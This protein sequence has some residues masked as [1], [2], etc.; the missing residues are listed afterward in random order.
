MR[1]IV[2]KLG[3]IFYVVG[4]MYAQQEPQYTQYIYATQLINP[5]YISTKEHISANLIY[6][7]QWLGF[8]GAP[9]TASFTMDTPMDKNKRIALGLSV[10]HDE[11]G[12][13]Q[14]TTMTI[15]YGYTIQ[16]QFDR[17]LSFGLK[18]GASVLDIDFQK[19]NAYSSTDP[20]FQ[21]NIDD[22]WQPHI[23]AGVFYYTPKFFLGIST[24]NF[25][26]TKYFAQN[27]N[28]QTIA[29]HRMHT[30]WLG[31][32]VIDWTSD[33][34]F[35][36][37]LLLKATMGAPLEWDVS[38]NFMFYE[39][40]QFGVVYRSSASIAAVAGFQIV[41]SWFVG[42]GYDRHL[43]GLDYYNDGTYELIMQFRLFDQKNC[44]PKNRF[45]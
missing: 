29:A 4:T 35:K 17:R 39:K 32:Y 21:N 3:W 43:G 12:P 22:R 16:L 9:K 37:T 7:T 26:E 42:F 31:G 41:K 25:L 1:G 5:A 36:P 33:I 24:P 45:Y 27:N 23:G 38:A 34:K 30:Y 44:C 14:Q 19:L 20:T 18:F 11:I 28:K 40:I 6:R 8:S 2:Y 10:L 13:A 15:D